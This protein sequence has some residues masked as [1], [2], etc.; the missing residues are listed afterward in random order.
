MKYNL[1]GILSVFLIT[2]SFFQSCTPAKEA[3]LSQL[4]Q[5]SQFDKVKLTQTPG[6]FATQS[7]ALT[8][9]DYQFEIVN[10][11]VDHEVGFV[12]V[13][14]GKYD[15]ADHIKAAY[16]TAPVATGKSAMTGVVALEAG[17]YEYF[18]PLNPTDKYPLLVGT[19]EKV[20]LT[21]VPGEFETTS[22]NLEEGLYQF[23]IANKGVDHEVGFVL[24]P[25]GKY[26]AADHI[27]AAYVT[28]PVATGKSAMT[29]V[30]ALEAGA[31]EYFC[32]LNPTDKYPLL[33]GTPKKVTLTQ[34]PGEFETTSLN[35]DAGVYQF[36]IANK[37]VDHEVG[38]VLVPKG[39]YDTAD[40]IKAAYVTAPVAT[41]K[42]AMTNVVA[43]EAGAYEYFCPLN[44][45]DKYSL[46]V[47]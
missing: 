37:G 7:L 21:Q 46:T 24:V 33:V 17:A 10:D 15:A 29:S 35:L 40:H 22:L 32:P 39:K 45:T 42:S 44:P 12:L 34:V 11:G 8:P 28:A 20:T 27:K 14:K 38:F 6:A 4:N 5:S 23:E 36:E 2:F 3:Q 41:G 18:C 26:D 25:K 9:G 19:P 1:T 30:V 16:V 13:P 31:Y 47:K 43:L